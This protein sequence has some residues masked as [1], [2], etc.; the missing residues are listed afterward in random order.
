MSRSRG[1]TP[2]FRRRLDEKFNRGAE[3][4][5]FLVESVTGIETLESDGGRAADAA[6]LGGAARG[7]CARQLPGPARSAKASQAV[8]F[9]SKLVT[10]ATCISA[11]G[12]D[13]RQMTVGE[14]V[15]FN[16]LAGRVSAPVLRLA[17][18]WQDFQQARISVERLGDIL[19][20]PRRA[21]LQPGARRA[22]A[23]PR[24]YQLRACRSS[25]TGSTGRRCCSDVKLEIPA[26][27]MVGIVGPSGSGKAR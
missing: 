7:L 14:L 8:Q 26:G 12:G 21:E 24:R 3:N 9:V 13:R 17:Q 15:A 10:A 19:N 1:V 6:P 16:M 11:P 23:D 27:Q 18:I 20:T 5:A 22:A 2:I 25:A 4:Q